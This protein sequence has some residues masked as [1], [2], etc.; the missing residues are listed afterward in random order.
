M[1][2]S[3]T[4]SNYCQILVLQVYAILKDT[5]RIKKNLTIRKSH[6]ILRAYAE[7][8][9]PH[10]WGGAE[11]PVKLQFGGVLWQSI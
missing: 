7:K 11:I 1:S 9:A 2:K 8:L 10:P 3:D 5:T 6:R 4:I